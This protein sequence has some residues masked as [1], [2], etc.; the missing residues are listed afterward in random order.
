MRA[1][2]KLVSLIDFPLGRSIMKRPSS[3]T[4]QKPAFLA[5]D[6]SAAGAKVVIKTPV[7][8]GDRRRGGGRDFD[9]CRKQSPSYSNSMASGLLEI[10]PE[11]QSLEQRFLAY[12]Q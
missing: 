2:Q 9:E 5:L 4:S 12:S 3:E 10:S 8:T 11:P 7:E 6:V 1:D